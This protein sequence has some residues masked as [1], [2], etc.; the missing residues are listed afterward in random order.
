[1][2]GSGIIQSMNRIE[3]LRQSLEQL[4]QFT[5]HFEWRQMARMLRECF[6]DARLG[7]TASSLT[8]T[9]VLAL[10]PLFTLG[11]A[12]FTAFPVFAKVQDQLQQWLVQSL[13]PESIAR[14]VLGSLTQ[15]SRKASRLGTVGFVAVLATSVAL[16]VTIER[17]LGQIWR[18]SRP[19][20]LA[21]RVLLYWAAITL[22]PL[23]LGGSLAITSYVVS[24][25]EGVGVLPSDLR[26]VLDAI[27]FLLLTACATGIYF[28]VP[29]TRVQWQHAL[30]GGLVASIGIE[31]GKKILTVYLAKMPTY[32]AIYGAFAAVPILLVWIYVAWVIVLVG[33]LVA[34]SLPEL[35]RHALRRRGGSGWSFR[36]ALETLGALQRTQNTRPYGLSLNEL[37]EALRIE[38]RHAQRVIDVLIQLEWIGLLQPTTTDTAVRYVLLTDLHATP[39]APLA[40]ALLVSKLDTTEVVWQRM[41]IE[42]LQLS[43]VI[44]TSDQ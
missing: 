34:A 12:I 23:M 26:F 35:G 14:Q 28:Y 43:D 13:V 7:I 20:P 2:H 8:F 36:L 3:R 24:A 18:V 1:M 44:P 30:A 19:R 37:A 15:F 25:S 40:N 42:R 9:T 29:N 22:G 33:A 21:Q 17:T 11:L 16:M 27:E 4:W 32:S 10:V 6:R 38:L 31:L 39:L 41:G 5:L